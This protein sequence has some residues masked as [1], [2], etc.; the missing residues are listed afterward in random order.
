MAG[1]QRSICVTKGAGSLD[2]NN[3]KFI[4]EN[5]DEYRTR[6][7]KTYIKEDELVAY[8]KCFGDAVREYDAKQTRK[9]RRIG[10]SKNYWNNV[11]T[12]GNGEKTF[13]EIIVQVGNMYDSGCLT[14]GGREAQKILDEYMQS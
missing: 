6:L 1:N 13:Y 11:R 3:R 7:N 12:S 8:E 5:V 9:N 14:E 2:H 10:S 4:A